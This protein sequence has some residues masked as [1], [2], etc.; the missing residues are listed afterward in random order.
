MEGCPCPLHCHGE[1]SPHGDGEESDGGGSEAA[2]SMP[3][4]ARS[5]DS[6]FTGDHEQAGNEIFLQPVLTPANLRDVT[7]G[8]LG[9]VLGGDQEGIEGTFCVL[10]GNLGGNWTQRS[11][12]DHM[13]F[14]IKSGPCSIIVLQEAKHDLL[15]HLRE[16][17][18]DG[19]PEDSGATRGSGVNWQRRPTSQYIGIRGAEQGS[20]LV[21]AARTSLLRG[22]R[23]LLFRKREEGHT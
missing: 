8:E 16:P 14:D 23:L 20:G 5:V 11:L 9:G 4:E 18:Q 2:R 7:D 17:G 15:M 21:I 13:H 3:S 10:C 6:C 12:Q 22:M 1:E 19:V